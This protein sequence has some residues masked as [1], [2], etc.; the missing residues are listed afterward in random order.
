V[1]HFLDWIAVALG[2]SVFLAMILYPA[3][4]MWRYF[5]PTDDPARSKGFPVLP[6]ENDDHHDA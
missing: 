1:S 4:W 2:V 3:F 5:R 6:P